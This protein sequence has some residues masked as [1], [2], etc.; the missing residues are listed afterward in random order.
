MERY[1]KKSDNSNHV[2]FRN[3]NQHNVWKTGEERAK[4]NDKEKFTAYL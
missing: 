3:R 1:L 2:V 4:L